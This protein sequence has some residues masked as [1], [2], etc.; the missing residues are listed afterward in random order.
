V[1]VG[2]EPGTA[3]PTI[4]W[5]AA[6]IHQVLALSG[7][8]VWFWTFVS[9]EPRWADVTGTFRIAATPDERA[10]L[11]ALTAQADGP[12]P[13]PAVELTVAGRTVRVA[14][15]SRLGLRV[16]AAVAPLLDRLRAAPVSAAVVSAA[17]IE[18]PGGLGPM[19]G[20][21]VTALGTQ[22]A[23]IGL[24]A[25]ALRIAGP[26]GPWQPVPAPRMGLVGPDGALL[27]GLYAMASVPAG[28]RGA[29][30]V[31]GAPMSGARRVRVAGTVRVVGPVPAAAV[32]FEVTAEIRPQ[33]LP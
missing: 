3:S 5:R 9:P 19:L 32:P 16:G 11:A 27:D 26:D 22:Q 12:A 29:W 6:G 8:D 20:L 30:V 13:G 25:D 18:P 17:V 7:D 21:T 4:V 31:P 28:G 24:T 1:T 23:V 10:A 14:A 33:P 2:L 15:G